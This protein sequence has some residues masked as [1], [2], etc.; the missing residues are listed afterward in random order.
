MRTF[1]AIVFASSAV[2]AQEVG[3]SGGASVASGSSAISNPNV[4]N[5]WQS[6]SS[7][8]ASD[9]A[10]ASTFNN[11]VGSS[12]SSLN[13]NTAIKDNLANNPS[14]TGVKGNSGWTANGDSNALGPVQNQLGAGFFRRSGD[15]VFADSHH[16]VNTQAGF[17]NPGFVAPQ[18][19]TP[20]FAPVYPAHHAVAAIT[21][22]DG[23][24]V[25]A[26]NHHQVNAHAT[27]FV[28][29]FAPVAWPAF[30]PQQ[31]SFVQPVHRPVEIVAEPVHRPVE[32]VAEPVIAPVKAEQNGQK[33]TIVQNQ[34]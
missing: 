10:G 9:G 16:Q 22:R 15:V 3:F 27:E 7:L 6:D 21:K 1:T 28:P 29:A 20:Q 8:F 34:A 33:A 19:V 5:G 24:V 13:A 4:N 17:V 25:F 2:L 23:D 11:V 18:F 30:V 12:F 26:E 31:V 32:V 14:F